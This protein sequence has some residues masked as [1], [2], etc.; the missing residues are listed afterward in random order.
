VS[1]KLAYLLFGIFGTMSILGLAWLVWRAIDAFH[2]LLGG[3]K[4][5]A[6]FD[7]A[8]HKL[9]DIASQV[10]IELQLLR[11]TVT[12]NLEQ[13]G[14][15]APE[16]EAPSASRPPRAPYPSPPMSMYRPVPNAKVEDT[17]VVDTS[18]E[19]YA[20]LERLEEVR[21]QGYEADPAELEES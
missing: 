7:Q 6:G 16:A 11:A 9:T 13:G 3:L 2:S 18:D 5:I 10:V 20:Q 15:D 17:E 14:V 1:D 21:Q 19:T 8:I 12:A 4:S